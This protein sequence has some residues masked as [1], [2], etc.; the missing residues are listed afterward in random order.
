MDYLKKRGLTD[1]IIKKF[2]LG[3]VP[4][5]NNFIEQLSKKFSLEDIKLTGLYYI[6]EKNKKLVD[7]FSNRIIFP[8]YNLSDDVIAFGGRIINNNNLAKY[9]NSPE[10]EF[11]KKGRQL[12]NLNFA[13]E[14]RGSTKEV[15]IVEGYMDVISLYSNGI[16]NVISN[17]GTAITENQINLIWKFFSNPII[18]LDGD[19]SGQQAAIRIA[20]RLFPL[21]NEES[22]IFFSILDKGKDPDDIIKDKGKSGFLKILEKK[23][24]I[25]SFIWDTYVSKINKNNPFEITKF[26]KQMRKLCSFIKDN[27]LKKYILEDF[28]NKINTLTPNVNTKLYPYFKKRI[29]SKVLNET[30]K[31]SF[32]K[33][34]SHK[35]KFNR[36]FY[37]TYY[38]F[39]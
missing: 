13:K 31:N 11:Y 8:I 17:S 30:K 14:E 36:I 1:E 23:L 32:T 21:I 4:K 15:V 2:R 12:F 28:L 18:C 35:R 25:Q 3:F 29:E 34:R 24:I 39:L 26:E 27:T 19:N 10:T 5:N 7:R 33:K 20:E 37:F 9:I 16:K 22:K 6:I 38:Y